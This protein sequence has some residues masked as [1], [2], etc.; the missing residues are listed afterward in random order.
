MDAAGYSRN[1]FVEFIIRGSTTSKCLSFYYTVVEQSA[2][3][4]FVIVFSR[5]RALYALSLAPT[6]VDNEWHF[7]AS[8]VNLRDDVEI[9]VAAI[10]IAGAPPGKGLF[11][12]DDFKVRMLTRFFKYYLSS[13]ILICCG[14]GLFP[15]ISSTTF[16]VVK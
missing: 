12:I 6:R 4:L 14:Y 11:I 2:W 16:R 10:K 5:G 13:V 9:T 15:C 1:A 8:T 3:M 7:V